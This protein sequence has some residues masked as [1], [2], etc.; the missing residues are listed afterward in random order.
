MV[1]VSHGEAKGTSLHPSAS[2][3]TYNMRYKDNR[4]ETQESQR[5]WVHSHNPEREITRQE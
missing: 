3:L 2:P 4:S 5:F 1:C